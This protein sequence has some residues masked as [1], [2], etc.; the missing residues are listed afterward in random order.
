MHGLGA[1]AGGFAAS[2]A[3]GGAL[4]DAE[5]LRPFFYFIS[6]AALTLKYPQPPVSS[7]TALYAAS[8]TS[9]KKKDLIV[10]TSIFQW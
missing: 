8:A 5:V 1:G 6:I 7:A 10:Y 9:K 2:G 3:A 4:D